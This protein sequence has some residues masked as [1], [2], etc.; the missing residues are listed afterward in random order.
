MVNITSLSRWYS[1]S[2]LEPVIKSVLYLL[3]Q[4]LWICLCSLSLFVKH[5]IRRNDA[6]YYLII[7]QP[8]RYWQHVTPLAR[9]IYV[10]IGTVWIAIC[11]WS[12]NNLQILFS[13]S[14]IMRS[15]QLHKK[16][17]NHHPSYAISCIL[18]HSIPTYLDGKHKYKS[19]TKSGCY[20]LPQSQNIRRIVFFTHIKKC[21]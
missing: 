17:D 14:C 20:I 12:C 16:K 1:I 18:F 21:C 4:L 11:C 5:K 19:K 3:T 10:D 13:S 8:S 15:R 7:K 2:G 6:Y 9:I